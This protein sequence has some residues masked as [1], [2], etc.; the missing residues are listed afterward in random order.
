LGA[1]EGD[2]RAQP[3]EQ[4]R[5]ATEQHRDHVHPD[6]IDQA[7]R[8]RLHH[9]GRAV[10]ADDLVARDLRGLLDRAGHAIGDEREHGWVRRGRLVVGDHEARDVTDGAAVAPT[11]VMASGTPASAA[12][13]YVPLR[14]RPRLGRLVV[15]GPPS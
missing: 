14:R 13:R 8:K 6:L 7:E 1:Y 10:Q 2:R 15:L 12:A 4:G 9:H 5:A 11:T 3:A